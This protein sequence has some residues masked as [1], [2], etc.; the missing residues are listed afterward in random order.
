[1]PKESRGAIGGA[2]ASNAIQ[3]A[4]GSCLRVESVLDLKLFALVVR[5]GLLVCVTSPYRYFGHKRFRLGGIEGVVPS[6][7]LSHESKDPSVRRVQLGTGDM[8]ASEAAAE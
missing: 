7:P 4:P 1:M 8:G 2:T 6:H 3:S 5:P